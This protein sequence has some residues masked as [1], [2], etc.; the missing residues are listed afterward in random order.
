MIK[1]LD[2]YK[3]NERYRSEIDTAIQNVLDSGWYLLGKQNEQFCHNFAKYCGSKYCIGV[4]NGL[5]ALSLIFKAYNFPENSEVV[6]SANT[7]I[8]SVLAISDNRLTPVLVEP[9]IDT[10][11]ID[12]DLI[13]QHITKKTTAIMVVHLYGQACEITKIMALA[14]KYNLKVIEDC[15]QAH[16]AYYPDLTQKVG[17]VGDASGF[18]F[19]PGKNLGALGDGGAV[20]T[21]N[22][23]LIDK[24]N[25]LRNY[26]SVEK[27]V[28]IYQG[29]NSRLD[30]IQAAIL[31]VKLQYLDDEI[32]QRRKVANYYLNNIKNPAFVL[33]TVVTQ[34]SHAWHLF[35]IR[36]ENRDKLQKYFTEKGIQ[37][38]IHYPIPPH[39]QQAYRE[40][41]NLSLPITEHIHERCLSLP[42]N[43]VLTESEIKKIVEVANEWQ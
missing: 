3:I 24:I 7:Y 4:A 23:V 39:K 21:N 15:A 11:N 34:D 43:A 31:D 20:T 10:Y 29:M 41:N 40:L 18:S 6:V 16:G 8:A 13:E 25:A 22:D 14:K 5:D 30:E 26:G 9:K 42:I 2:L 35:V 37:T 12:V 19:Y 27:Y 32:I 28:N 17:S 33:P 1:F 38:S 36:C